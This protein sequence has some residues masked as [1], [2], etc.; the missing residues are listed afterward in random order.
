MPIS[1]SLKRK[2]VGTGPPANTL[3][4]KPSIIASETTNYDEQPWATA[5]LHHNVY[6]TCNNRTP[7]M[8]SRS[9]DDAPIPIESEHSHNRE[10]VM[11]TE[12][13][14]AVSPLPHRDREVYIDPIAGHSNV[15]IP[16]RPSRKHT[17]SEC[18]DL[19]D[20]APGTQIR[21]PSGQLLSAEEL[22]TRADRPMGIKERQEAIRRKVAEQREKGL[23]NEVT[24]VGDA[25]GKEQRDKERREKQQRQMEK[26][27]KRERLKA[28]AAE[29]LAGIF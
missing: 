16:A 26:K 13:T 22:A 14:D 23:G 28:K 24:I 4:K 19:D 1:Y 5:H 7:I 8:S 9:S 27:S 3:K 6:R 18:F 20:L 17:Y 25:K 15:T 11:A 10:S 21:S 29:C 2:P 12:D